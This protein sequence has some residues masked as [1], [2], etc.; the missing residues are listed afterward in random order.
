MNLLRF[1]KTRLGQ[2]LESYDLRSAGQKMDN[3]WTELEKVDVVKRAV[4]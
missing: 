4:N 2:K 3:Y 1:A